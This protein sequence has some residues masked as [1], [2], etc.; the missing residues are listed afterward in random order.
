MHNREHLRRRRALHKNSAGNNSKTAKSVRPIE[1]GLSLHIAG[2][3]PL[4]FVAESVRYNSTSQ[5]LMRA[6]VVPNSAK[7]IEDLTSIPSKLLRKAFVHPLFESKARNI[8]H[9]AS[10]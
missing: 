4:K 1:Q 5:S 6:Q 7:P 8:V 9:F 2:A 3:E 10:R